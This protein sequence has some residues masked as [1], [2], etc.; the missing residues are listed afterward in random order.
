MKQFFPAVLLL[1]LQLSARGQG[2]DPAKVGK[3]AAIAYQKALEIARDG[4]FRE[5]IRWVDQAIAA[6]VRFVDAYLSKA[7]LHGELK[8]Y[9]SAVE[10]YEKAFSIDKAYT[11]EY[12]LPYAINLAGMGSFALAKT[13]LEDFL[14]SSNI[15]ERSRKAASYR[16][17]CMNFARSIDSL[18]K[19]RNYVF[20]PRNMGDSINSRDSECF[21][22]LTIDGKTL[23]FTRRLGG[24]NEDFFMSHKHP[25]GWGLAGALSGEVNSALN[26]GAQTLSLDGQL[27][28]FTGCN[29]PDGFGSCD[30]YFS[31]RTR[32]GWSLPK[33]VGEDVN[34]EAWESAPSLSPD[35]RSLY[36]ASSMTGGQGG[37]DIWVTRRGKDGRWSE[38]ENLGP[39]VNTPGNESSPFIHADNQSL[40]FTSNGHR[41]YGG[42]D[43]F[44]SRRQAD[45][46]WSVPENLG[47][48]INTIENEGSMIVSADGR[49]AYYASDRADS[50]GGLDLYTFELREDVRPVST[51][52]VE[53]QVLD[54]MTH[55]GLPSAVDLVDLTSGRRLSSIQT[56]EEGFYM[57]P[58]PLGSDYAFHVNRKGYL[59]FSGNFPFS[60][61]VPDSTYRMDIPL[62]PVRKDA[63]ITLRNIFFTTGDF[64]LKPESAAELD[65][66]VK[67][68][69]ENPR[70]RIRINGHTDNVGQAAD[71]MTLST[72]RARAVTD[73]LQSKGIEA[74]R[75]SFQ[76]YGSSRPVA[77]NT[78]EEGRASNRRT[79]LEILAQ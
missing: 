64:N 67:W 7:G 44:L 52:W 33:N 58:L 40:Y 69:Q 49:T 1:M 15:D 48:P 70:V 5:A 54:S 53:G 78:I 38:P 30:L 76:G 4:Q 46:R 55:V 32:T 39:T 19:D 11:E 56:D 60:V 75:L 23:V 45:D 37:S 65:I 18:K 26:E 8:E 28:F 31:I 2:Y 59:F 13:T 22:A 47:Y 16:L 35:K 41:G 3:K 9:S 77:P 24:R 43:L 61:R 12:R 79:E 72:R 63:Q 10:Q 36:F 66:I 51:L 73:Y 27:L 20:S 34:T 25:D 14:A 68:L 50:R 62:Q 42:D 21:P 17:D 71:N 29:F 57:M 6:D 74:G